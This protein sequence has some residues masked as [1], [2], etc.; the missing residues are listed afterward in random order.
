MIA[1]AATE[2]AAL[3]RRARVLLLD[4][5]GPICAIFAG[6]PA[7]LV[8][9]QLATSLVESG[10]AVPVEVL[11]CKDPFEVFR[12]AATLS[13]HSAAQTEY[14]LRAAEIA[15]VPSARPTP[16]ADALIEAW[17]KS[18]RAVAAVSNNSEDAVLAYA[19]LHG[20]ALS[21]IVGRTSED[22]S[23]LKPHPHLVF[24]ALSALSARA[25]DALLVGD[26]VSDIVAGARAGVPTVGFANKPGKRQR[27]A[28]AD[29]HVVV[30]HLSQILSAL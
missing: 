15:A 19:G 16:Q 26:S 25:G 30:D 21:T 4:F 9:R 22:P 3:V 17:T 29:A 5:D 28:E 13:G 11:E 27:L 18:G 1:P 2:L 20:L 10:A 14:R 12:F 24:R 7:P 8:A 6:H 23:L